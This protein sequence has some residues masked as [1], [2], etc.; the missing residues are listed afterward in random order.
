MELKVGWGKKKKGEQLLIVSNVH[1]FE[2]QGP[3]PAQKGTSL[4]VQMI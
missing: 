3:L 4:D 2:E 1:I